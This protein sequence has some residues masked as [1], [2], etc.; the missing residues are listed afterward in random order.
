LRIAADDVQQFLTRIVPYV[1]TDGARNLNKISRELRIPY[2]TLHF[3]MSRLRD[4]GISI[5]PVVNTSALGL[6]RYRVLFDVPADMTNFNHAS[7]FDSLHQTTGLHYYGRS[8][9]SY[10]FDCEFMIPK[11][12]AGEFSKVLKGLED[13]SLIERTVTRKLLWKEILMMK[14][15]FYDYSNGAWDVDYSDLSG[16]PSIHESFAEPQPIQECD[17]VDLHLVKS[18]RMDPSVKLVKVGKDIG[19]TD[20]DVA[21]H[22]KKHVFGRKQVPSFRFLWVGTKEAWAKHTIILM[23]YLFKTLTDESTR[24]AMSVFTALPFTWNH[25]RGDDGSYMAELAIP[26]S[27]LADAMHYLSYNLRPLNLKPDEILY[28][29]WSCCQNYT[30]PNQLFRKEKGWQLNAERSLSQVLQT[31]RAKSPTLAKS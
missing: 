20:S 30:V 4:Q 28:P 19:L 8:L 5:V 2:Q 27:Q 12:K 21:Y 25:M 17:E 31:I 15:Q 14:T 9:A 18:L 7:F 6:E 1:K 24:H 16:D 11:G 10:S 22:L 13:M 26:V 29:D 3:R 23:T